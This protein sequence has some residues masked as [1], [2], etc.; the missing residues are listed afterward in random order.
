MKKFCFLIQARADDEYFDRFR[1]EDSDCY[2]LT[3]KEEIKKDKYIYAPGSSWSRGRN[4]LLKEAYRKEDYEYYVFMDDD[5]RI[6]N[7]SDESC[8]IEEF[9]RKLL[10]HRP[11]IG[12]PDYY[13]HL[14]L[15]ASRFKI[16]YSN[17]KF[18]RPIFFDPCVNA[19]HKDCIRYVLPYEVKFDDKNWWFSQEIMNHFARHFL[20]NSILQFNNLQTQNLY[21]SDYPADGGAWV[22]NEGYDNWVKWNVK[23]QERKENCYYPENRVLEFKELYTPINELSLSLED[24]FNSVVLDGHFYLAN[25]KAFWEA[26]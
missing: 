10:K 20:G 15:K 11:A 24:R 7:K 2:I 1:T 13:W 5:T 9:K 3:F 23:K 6:I 18:S 19:F 14:N 17:S 25:N 4:L 16:K 12:F 21:S 26:L 22:L 8:G